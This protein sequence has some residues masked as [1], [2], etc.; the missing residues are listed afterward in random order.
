MENKNTIKHLLRGECS[1]H[2]I[3][4]ATDEEIIKYRCT[5]KCLKCGGHNGV[6]E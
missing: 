4:F 1:A 5:L 6:Q 3:T 2:D